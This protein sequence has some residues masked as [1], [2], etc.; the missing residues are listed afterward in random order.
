MIEASQSSL[1]LP[2]SSPSSPSKSKR[3]KKQLEHKIA[4]VFREER[5]EQLA[6]DIYL[7]S[8]DTPSD[9]VEPLKQENY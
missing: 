2:S 1:P 9:R 3:I 5:R 8:E 6:Q 4:T 7:E